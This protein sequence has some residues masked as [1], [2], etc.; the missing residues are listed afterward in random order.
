MDKTDRQKQAEDTEIEVG[1][2]KVIGNV[3]KVKLAD[4]RTEK[5]E[6]GRSKLRRQKLKVRGI[7][8]QT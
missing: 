5:T 4:D 7:E 2:A 6:S 8:K 1:K 3:S